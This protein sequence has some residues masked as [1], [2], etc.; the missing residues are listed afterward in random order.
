VR[1]S[2]RRR[3]ARLEG[4]RDVH[5]PPND[6]ERRAVRLDYELRFLQSCFF[7]GGFEGIARY[8]RYTLER[9][10][11]PVRD[12]GGRDP[13]TGGRELMERVISDWARRFKATPEQLREALV[14]ARRG[15]ERPFGS[16]DEFSEYHGSQGRSRRFGAGSVEGWLKTNPPRWEIAVAVDISKASPENHRADKRDFQ[17]PLFQIIQAIDEHFDGPRTRRERA[18]SEAVHRDLVERG[19]IKG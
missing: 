9:V 16:F 14:A 15:W 3:V 4:A 19:L 6:E 18:R 7:I 1:G 2:L 12:Y 17:R 8:W 11:R 5:R 10:S 13:S